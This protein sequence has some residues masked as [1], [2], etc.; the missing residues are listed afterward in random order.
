MVLESLG[1]EMLDLIKDLITKSMVFGR[2][3]KLKKY[4]HGGSGYPRRQNLE[5]FDLESSTRAQ[6][7]NRLI[8]NTGAKA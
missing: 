7:S 3:A 5:P 1:Q 8:I 2:N 6:T 4:G